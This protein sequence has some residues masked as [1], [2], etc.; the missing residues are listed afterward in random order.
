MIDFRYIF[1]RVNYYM[2]NPELILPPASD[3]RQD[4][5]I[6]KMRK[7]ISDFCDAKREIRVE[8]QNLASENVF[9]EVARQMAK[10]RQ[11]GQR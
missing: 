4:A 5:E 1:E 9:L 8:N 10:D 6:A 2:Q 7:A 3:A 11:R